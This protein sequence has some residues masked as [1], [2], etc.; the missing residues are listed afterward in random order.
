MDI[1]QYILRENIE[2]PELYFAKERDVFE[3]NGMLLSAVDYIERLP[4]E[5]VFQKVVRYR[6]VGDMTCT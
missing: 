4:G 3:R 5:D 1:W 2:I 6:T